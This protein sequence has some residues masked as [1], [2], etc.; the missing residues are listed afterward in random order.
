MHIDKGYYRNRFRSKTPKK[1]RR[2][3]KR[4]KKKVSY[5]IFLAY[6][7]IEEISKTHAFASIEN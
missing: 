7:F 4:I 6:K 5:V 2:K 1:D 3:I